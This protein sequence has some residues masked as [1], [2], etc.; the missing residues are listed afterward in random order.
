MGARTGEGVPVWIAALPMY[1]FPE[2][3]DAHDRLWDALA[4]DRPANIRYPNP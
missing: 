3:R 2:V 1:D 4:R